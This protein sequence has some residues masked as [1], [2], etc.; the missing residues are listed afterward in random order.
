MY[1]EKNLIIKYEFSKLK[2][3]LKHKQ[4]LLKKSLYFYFKNV[5]KADRI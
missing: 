3:C 4:F 5:T 2:C 1:W